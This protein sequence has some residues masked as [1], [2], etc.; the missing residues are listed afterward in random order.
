MHSQLSTLGNDSQDGDSHSGLSFNVTALTSSTSLITPALPAT[1]SCGSARLLSMGR[2]GRGPLD[3]WLLLC[4]LLPL[5]TFPVARCDPC[6]QLR[7]SA[8]I[9][10]SIGI[11]FS[12]PLMVIRCLTSFR[13]SAHRDL[14]VIDTVISGLDTFYVYKQL[15]KSSPSPRLP[16]RIDVVAQL[17]AV[18][19]AAVAGKFN[20]TFRF[21]EKITSVVQSLNDGHTA[22]IDNCMQQPSYLGL[23]VF[24][25][26]EKGVQRVRVIPLTGEPPF[27]HCW[28]RGQVM[29]SPVSRS[30]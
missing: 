14:P 28:L 9:A 30:V 23:P 10:Q 18:R 26:V 15:A 3:V 6:T 24:G 16:S 29:P 1:N 2:R 21:F 25:T 7:Q 11:A 5:Q 12:T 19:A 20:S 22:F 8:R 4:L 13:F 27:S 17:Q